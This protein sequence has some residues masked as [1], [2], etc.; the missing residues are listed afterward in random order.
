MANITYKNGCAFDAG[1]HK[2]SVESVKGIANCALH[3]FGESAVFNVE[4]EL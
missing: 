2:S 3:P 4:N 1:S